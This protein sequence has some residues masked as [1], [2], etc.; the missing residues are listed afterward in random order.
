[1]TGA[2]GEQRAAELLVKKGYRILDRNVSFKNYELDIVC[3]DPKFNEI[4]FVEVK[5]RHTDFYGLPSGAVDYKKLRSINR[6]AQTYLRAKHWSKF[7][8]FDIIAVT[9]SNIGH[10]ENI[11]WP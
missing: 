8:R 1:M 9:P 4:V 10:F 3:L 5:T 7:F 6:A 11:T 2:N